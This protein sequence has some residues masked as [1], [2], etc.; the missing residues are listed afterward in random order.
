MSTGVVSFYNRLKGWG[1]VVPDCQTEPDA[2][3]H[4]TNLPPNRKFTFVGERIAYDLGDRDGKPI[5][6]N[7]RIIAPSTVPEATSYDA[8]LDELVALGT[9]RS[10][11]K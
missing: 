8:N 6:L 4:V 9:S 1:F 5:A 2:F 10:A 11:G 3:V 7:I